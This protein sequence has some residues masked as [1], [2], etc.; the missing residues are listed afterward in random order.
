MNIELVNFSLDLSNMDDVGNT[1]EFK[2]DL[3]FDDLEFRSQKIG[4]PE[5]LHLDLKVYNT[6]NTFLLTGKLSGYIKLR[7]SR[8][9]EKFKKE[10]NIN[11]EKE[12]EKS[13]IEN[14]DNVK[15]DEILKNNIFLNIPIKPL[16]DEDCKGLC[17]K[18][19][20]NLNKGD[21]DC[22]TETVDPRL[23]KLENFF[24]DEN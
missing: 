1:K 11:I 24:D 5:A 8:C 14:L 17:P 4:I 18:C 20:Q 22:D 6:N 19:G 3:I 2:V 16:C 23:A 12:I 7:C 13:E 21:C 15:I 10:I 9:L